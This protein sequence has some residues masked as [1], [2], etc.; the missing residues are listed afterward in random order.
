MLLSFIFKWHYNYKKRKKM[1]QFSSLSNA[2]HPFWDSNKAS[3]LS[4][5]ASKK[6]FGKFFFS[7][8]VGVFKSKEKTIQLMEPPPATLEKRAF[9]HKSYACNKPLF[10]KY[11]LKWF[12][13]FK[14]YLALRVLFC[15]FCIWLVLESAQALSF[16]S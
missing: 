11:D 2:R 4:R 10:G 3:A 12:R 9:T 6:Y 16:F 7:L 14:T 15:A 13:E 1:G 5:L 8:L